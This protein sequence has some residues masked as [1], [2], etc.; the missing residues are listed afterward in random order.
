MAHINNAT[1]YF[2]YVFNLKKEEVRRIT[3]EPWYTA[4]LTSPAIKTHPLDSLT[5]LQTATTW[6]GQEPAFFLSSRN[7]FHFF[8]YLTISTKDHVKGPH[9]ESRMHAKKGWG[10]TDGHMIFVPL[11]FYFGHGQVRSL[12]TAQSLGHKQREGQGLWRT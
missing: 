4:I 1:L 10:D 7:Y 8:K 12:H 11:S 3:A 9:R 2:H 6:D 5:E